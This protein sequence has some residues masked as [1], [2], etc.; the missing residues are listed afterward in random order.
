MASN[1]A[2]SVQFRVNGTET[3]RDGHAKLNARGARTLALGGWTLESYLTHIVL[4]TEPPGRLM[5][6]APDA[7]YQIPGN[8]C[9]VG[10]DDVRADIAMMRTPDG[11]SRLE[12]SGFINPAAV[13]A[14]PK[15]APANTLGI[16][17]IMFAVTEIDSVVA[18]LCARGAELMGEVTQYENLYRLCYL[19]GPEGIIIALA[20]ELS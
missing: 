11:Q 18:R 17:R 14:A 7:E 9:V 15:N 8:L 12:L 1:A 10:L 2:S 16:R 20:E 5:T 3:A 6:T 4:T 19:R 13:I